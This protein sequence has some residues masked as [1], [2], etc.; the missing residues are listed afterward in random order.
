M[1]N[2]YQALIVVFCPSCDRQVTIECPAQEVYDGDSQKGICQNCQQEIR[3][4]I[5]IK[6]EKI[7]EPP[8]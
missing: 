5:K 7:D 3:L 6:I 8:F 2:A 1:D 4:T